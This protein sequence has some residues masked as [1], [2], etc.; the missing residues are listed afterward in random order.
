MSTLQ[1]ILLIAALLAPVLPAQVETARI[2]GTV[3][4]QSGGVIPGAA[5]TFTNTGTN[6]SYQT[7]SRGDGSYESVPLHI[8]TYRVTAE[9]QGF[10]RVM[11]EGVVL[12]IQQTAVLDLNMEVGAVTQ[13]IVVSADAP[14]LTMN[15]ATQGQVIDNRKVVDL[16]LN[17]RDYI[18]LALLS[19]GAN[20]QA[21]GGRVGGFSGSGMRATQNNYLL[22]GVDNNSAQIAYQGRQ[23]EAVKPNVDAI[24]EFKVMTNSFSAEYGRATGAIVSVSMK[25]GT[26]DLHGSAFE[27]VRNEKLD[28]KNFFDLPDE[29][30]PP[31]KRN[32]FGFSLGGPVIRNKTFFF[33]DYEWSRIHESRTVN[34]T[35][36][37]QKMVGGDFSE[38]LPSTK[39]Y[40]PASYAGGDRT[41]Y[42]GNIIP[43]SKMD[44]I[45]ARLATF[46]PVP[47]KPGITRNFL[48]NPP[49]NTDR[50]HW[51]I[52]IDHTFSERNSIYGRYSYQQDLEPR[53]PSLPPPAWGTGQDA[54][55]FTHTG[56]NVMLGWNHLF[57]PTLILATKAAWNRLLTDRE[58]PV[59]RS[60]N[61][62]LGLKGVNTTIPGMA[63]FS[64]SGYT[65]LGI[66]GT[67]PNLADSQNR[68]LISDLTWMRGRH[69]AKF[70]INFSWL[71]AFLFNPQDAVGN[72]SF[73]GG[74][75]RNTRTL[76]EGNAIA[77]LLLG[78]PF[79]ATT[80]TFAYMNQR[81]TFYDAYALDEWRVSQ[82]LTLNFG[83]RYEAHLPWVES[84]NLWSNFDLDTNPARP[85]LVPAKDGSRFDR[86]TIRPDYNDIGPRFG[87]AYRALKHTVLRGGYGVYF[88]QYEGFGGA[89]FL[90]TNP[91]FTYRSVLS[92][93][94]ID[95]T[96]VLA[97]GLPPDI[98]SPKN[99]ANIQTSSY[100]VNLR[101][102]YAQ[103]WSFSIQHELPGDILLE[104]GYYANSAHKLMRR[105][106]GN[107]AL[108]GAGNVNTRR[109]YQSILV[110][111][112][113]VT[114]GPLAGTYRHEATVDANFHSFQVKLEKRLGRGV[115]VLSS[116]IWS[117]A[118]SNG[119]GESG[120]GGVSSGL[121][122]DPLNLRAER[123]LAD[124]H[125]PHRWV[126]SYVYNLP[127]GRGKQFLNHAPALL[128]AALGGWTLA[129]ITTLESGRL[130]S[131]TV[132]GNPSNTGGPD[133]PDAVHDWH[134]PSGQRSL[135]QWFDITA[136][137]PNAAFKYGNA[138]RNLIGGPG[139]VNLDLAIYKDF[140]VK[141]RARVQFRAEAFNATN[142]PHFG[143]PNA[144]VGDPT[145]GQING[146]GDGRNLQ[147]GLKIIF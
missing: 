73:D 25:S 31:F 109:R 17:G 28:A 43:K 134:L 104:A 32:Q 30:K 53:S 42:A 121:P 15:E 19:A 97:V 130:Q 51:D 107:W 106:E 5:I 114:V 133:R 36:P 127:F 23:G 98:I 90:E 75:T 49:N 96:I 88:A 58:P 94:R 78:L 1:R 18:Q 45:G 47:N 86:A 120:A 100:D 4:D 56:H 66:G 22:D 10:K 139:V 140:R 125:R 14:L 79:Q 105:T 71:Q 82:R 143:V 103:Q 91:P 20:E 85:A 50:D 111:Q 145:F 59:D 95:P 128:D 60:I 72:F 89:Q 117:K 81:T 80:S 76:R 113:G 84:R 24:Q 65:A 74:Y 126:T 116:Y 101:H 99:A 33:G 54:G 57:S 112:Q 61:A 38:L 144:N 135:N 39:I 102:G 138:G 87:F 132:R 123:S 37:T 110:P 35:I 40:D 67:T 34:N 141:D 12:Q 77:D 136:F 83:L 63:A 46:Y 2:I 108:P 21:P 137:V 68:Q 70:G 93:N 55:D 6:I 3:R 16:P 11:R 64:V 146:A 124:E 147:F 129:G 7:Q 62:E 119:R 41:P 118:I 9:R 48:F 52:K 92:T 122:Q 13:D 8:G 131:L 29:P 44:A 142:T 27:F 69:S 26:N 115:S